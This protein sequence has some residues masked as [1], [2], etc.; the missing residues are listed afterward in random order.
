VAGY[1][2]QTHVKQ[3][4]ADNGLSCEQSPQSN[5]VCPEICQS[6]TKSVCCLE[7]SKRLMHAPSTSSFA[8]THLS[9]HSWIHELRMGWRSA[10]LSKCCMP[11]RPSLYVE[12]FFTTYS[13][14]PDIYCPR[15]Q[16][17]SQ[18]LWTEFCNLT[19][20]TVSDMQGD[21]STS[22]VGNNKRYATMQ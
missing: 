1:T 11:S 16:Y 12:A 4:S 19:T 9:Y 5:K 14:M 15:Q 10:E 18:Y 17:V 6:N 2:L 8:A 7:G 13:L 3:G 21:A 22:C 20:V